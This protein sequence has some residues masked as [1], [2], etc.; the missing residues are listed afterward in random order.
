MGS[1][2]MGSCKAW[3]III[4]FVP[5]TFTKDIESRCRENWICSHQKTVQETYLIWYMPYQWDHEERN[6]KVKTKELLWR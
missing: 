6:K 2:F 5:F 1:K 3:R 4:A